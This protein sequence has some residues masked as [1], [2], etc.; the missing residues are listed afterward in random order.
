M[1]K[2]WIW[3]ILWQ[4]AVQ[5]ILFV[6]SFLRHSFTQDQIVVINQNLAFLLGVDTR[7]YLWDECQHPEPDISHFTVNNTQ[8]AIF[9]RERE[10]ERE[11][12]GGNYEFIIS[13]SSMNADMPVIET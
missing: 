9:L 5:Y 11:R 12:E 1:Y 4:L 2:C 6:P 8:L 10:R 3:D 7:E 13:D